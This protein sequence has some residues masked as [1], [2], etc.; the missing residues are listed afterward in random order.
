MRVLVS[1]CNL[2]VAF[3]GVKVAVILNHAPDRVPSHHQGISAYNC[4][5]DNTNTPIYSRAAMACTSRCGCDG[6]SSCE[7][8]FSRIAR[9]VGISTAPLQMHECF[10]Q[11]LSQHSNSGM[12]NIFDM[13]SYELWNADLLE[14]DPALRAWDARWMELKS[15]PINDLERHRHTQELV[16]RAILHKVPNRKYVFSFCHNKYQNQTGSWTKA[17]GWQH[18]SSCNKCRVDAWH[19]VKC[20]VCRDSTDKPCFKCGGVSSTYKPL[21]GCARRY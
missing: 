13:V 5:Y 12:Q 14:N 19:C 7:N 1:T 9:L 10:R 17:E 16:R 20:D 4:T 2:A 6:D 11:W 8:P 21:T 15:R 3:Y 18:C